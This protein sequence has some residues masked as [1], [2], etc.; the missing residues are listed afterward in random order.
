MPLFVVVHRVV[1]LTVSASSDV[2][3]VSSPPRTAQFDTRGA[4]EP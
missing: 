3:L 1:K 4:T 2:C